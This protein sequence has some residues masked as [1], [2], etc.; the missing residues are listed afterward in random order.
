MYRYNNWEKYEESL[1]ECPI[2]YNR[3]YSSEKATLKCGHI[4]HKECLGR[5]AG[6]PKRNAMDINKTCPIC[7]GALEL[8]IE[9][10]MIRRE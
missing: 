1:K 6:E 3:I 10:G 5:W 9:K 7:R 2:C 8:K 4:M